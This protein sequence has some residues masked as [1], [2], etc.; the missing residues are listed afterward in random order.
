M[1]HQGTGVLEKGTRLGKYA[2]E[3]LVGFG[4]MGAVYESV[5]S[6]G[7]RFAIKVLSPILAALP[8]ARARF[9]KEAK[10]A[11]RVRHPHVVD[12]SEVGEDAGHCYLVMEMLAG[13]DLAA[14]IQRAGML[15]VAQT[16]EIML[17]V[18]DAVAAAH[19]QGVIHRD[20][21]PS[22]IFI[23][24]RDGR[25][26][27]V[28]LDFGVATDGEAVP[29]DGAAPARRV[30]FGTPYY[31]APEQVADHRA[32]GPASDQYAL[33]VILYECLTGQPP[34]RGGSLDEVFAAI[35]AGRP[36]PPSA[37]RSDIPRDLDAV[38]LRALS[39]DPKA[40]FGWVA[41]LRRALL[42]FASKGALATAAPESAPATPEPA[43]AAASEPTL[44][45]VPEPAP[46][47]P[48]APDRQ[49]PPSSPAIEA[50]AA[51]PSPFVRT[52]TP[53]VEELSGA[54]F[55]AGEA[56]HEAAG[57]PAGV[58]A[59]A[60]D[61]GQDADPLFAAE[62]RESALRRWAAL[63]AGRR[64]IWA[65][66]AA[67]IVLATVLVVF[68]A[69]RGRSS[70]ARRPEAAPAPAAETV[71][72]NEPTAAP[73][74]PAAPAP[75]AAPAAAA[76]EPAAPPAA[77]EPP[78]PAAV[79]ATAPAPAPSEP[80]AP[81]PPAP[82]AATAPAAAPSEPAAPPPPPAPAPAPVAATAP[83][84]APSEAP[85]PASTRA[86]PAP[87]QAPTAAAAPRAPRPADR[88]RARAGAQVRMHNGVPLLD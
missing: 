14:R 27:P 74:A 42:P 45:A 4:S 20:L 31:L 43:P 9:L 58:P 18:C 83:A 36:S 25:P 46:E 69:T 59:L 62:P 68:V 35:A 38:V 24:T 17:P 80:S 78:A 54:W 88:P 11:S 2:I 40:R 13:E 71:V 26:H 72:Q 86:A 21:K 87:D 70:A 63:V 39:T 48:A 8:S 37:R 66:T 77:G 6:D 76:S 65:G 34:F 81:P 56:A 15:S 73:P 16:I 41:A 1:E 53:E 51:T 28:V 23:A 79:A 50:E 49:T 19:R 57:D 30:V 10:L 64:R 52:L 3:R 5:R 12:V 75:V 32:A 60:D 55:A 67:G 29:A 22:N 47:E 82:V 33:G 7:K 85:I 61:L 44:A 84:P